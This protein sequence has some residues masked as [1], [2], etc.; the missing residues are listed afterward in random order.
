MFEIELT[1]CIKIDFAINNLQRLICHKTQP[2]NHLLFPHIPSLITP[3]L[4]FFHFFSFLSLSSFLLFL[5]NSKSFQGI[6]FVLQNCHKKSHD[7]FFNTN[8][9]LWIKW[10]PF[11]RHIKYFLLVFVFYLTSQDIILLRPD[12]GSLEPKRYNVDFLLH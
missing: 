5:S 4:S 8:A 2:T 7:I 3:Y 1:I 6:L 10:L 9:D 12:D 11:S